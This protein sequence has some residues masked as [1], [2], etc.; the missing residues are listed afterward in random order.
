MHELAADYSGRM[1]FEVVKYNEG[2]SPQRIKDYGID[3]NLF[4]DHSQIVQLE[5]L[6]AGIWGTH[7][8][9]GRMLAYRG[10]QESM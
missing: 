7:D 4:V 2:D 6:R 5:G 3:V 10:D 1:T 9:W 8:T